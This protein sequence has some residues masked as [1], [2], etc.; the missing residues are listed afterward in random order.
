MRRSSAWPLDGRRAGCRSVPGHAG[1]FRSLRKSRIRS[2]SGRR[3]HGSSGPRAG[4]SAVLHR[5]TPFRSTSPDGRA[6]VTWVGQDLLLGGEAGAKKIHPESAPGTVH[7]KIGD[8]IGWMRIVS[9]VPV[10]VRAERQSLRISIPHSTAATDPSFDW[11]VQAP[12][13][14]PKCSTTS[15]GLSPSCWSASNRISPSPAHAGR[16][17]LKIHCAAPPSDP[18]G[19][20][21]LRFEKPP[22]TP[23]KTVPA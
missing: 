23:A 1:P 20:L 22:A 21:T 11:I 18:V 15:I 14:D 9:A 17:F 7:W 3:R 19:F 4:E 12:G 6:A 2:P 5:G 10:D 8:D 13:A 16:R